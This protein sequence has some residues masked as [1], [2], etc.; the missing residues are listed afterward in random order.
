M[1]CPGLHLARVRHS[2]APVRLSTIAQTW[3]GL[4]SLSPE[5][6]LTTVSELDEEDLEGR[7]LEEEDL[8][9]KDFQKEYTEEKDA[10]E[11]W[12]DDI[13]DCWLMATNFRRFLSRRLSNL[14]SGGLETWLWS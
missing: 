8:E 11:L 5:E 2:A 10:A 14:V 1:P 4:S 12:E 7:G 9:G 3:L 6:N 13:Q